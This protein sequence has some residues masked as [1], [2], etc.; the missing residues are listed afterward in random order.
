MNTVSIDPFDK[1]KMVDW[2]ESNLLNLQSGSLL[3]WDSHFAL[4]D[5]GVTKQI[6]DSDSSFVNIYNASKID[7]GKEILMSMYLKK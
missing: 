3:I 2:N 6:I 5:L 7:Q 1:T 4:I